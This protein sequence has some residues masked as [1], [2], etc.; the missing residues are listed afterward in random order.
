MGRCADHGHAPVAGSRVGQVPGHLR[1]WSRRRGRCEHPAGLS[2][3]APPSCPR[4]G[5]RRRV[6]PLAGRVPGL[7]GAGGT[8]LPSRRR[9]SGPAHEAASRS[10]LVQPGAAP[11]RHV[12]PVLG[13][14]ARARAA[15]VGRSRR[16]WHREAPR[17]PRQVAA[18]SLA[19]GPRAHRG[20]EPARAPARPA[21]GRPLRGTPAGAARSP[22]HLRRHDDSQRRALSRAARS[23]R[24][25]SRVAPVAARPLARHVRAGAA[26]SAGRAGTSDPPAGRRPV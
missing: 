14:P 21:R 3:N 5:Q 15:L 8:A 10:H 16:G 25:S 4:G 2:R 23:R 17:R 13:S 11:R 19:P 6:G 20:S 18:P 9:A 12:R 7:G 1:A 24:R 26:S 22:L